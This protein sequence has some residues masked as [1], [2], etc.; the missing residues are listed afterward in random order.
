MNAHN[1]RSSSQSSA[2]APGSSTVSTRKLPSLFGEP[3]CIEH[4]SQ[5]RTNDPRYVLRVVDR[6]YT[7]GRGLLR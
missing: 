2:V 6:A 7:D 1:A 4:T 3:P 5:R